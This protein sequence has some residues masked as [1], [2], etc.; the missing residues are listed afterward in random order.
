MENLPMNALPSS[1]AAATSVGTREMDIWM[2]WYFPVAPS[3]CR[4]VSTWWACGCFPMMDAFLWRNQYFFGEISTSLMKSVPLW[5]NQY[6]FGEI[7]TSLAISVL[8]WRN[9]YT[10]F[11]GEN[12]TD[13]VKSVFY[14]RNQ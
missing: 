5:R 3:V 12:G 1:W 13:L 14:L 4:T 7:S 10:Y 8:L 9:Q 2:S 6:F 11:F